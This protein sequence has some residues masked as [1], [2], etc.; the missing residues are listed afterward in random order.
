MNKF[1]NSF[2]YI[3]GCK[4]APMGALVSS[5]HKTHLYLLAGLVRD[6]TL[7][8]ALAVRVVDVALGE[9][10]RKYDEQTV[11]IFFLRIVFHFR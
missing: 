11:V 8:L 6:N 9:E 10:I 4:L 1:S 5:K 7:E 3:N 2:V